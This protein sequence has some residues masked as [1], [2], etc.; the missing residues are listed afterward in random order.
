MRAWIDRY[1]ALP[2]QAQKLDALVEASPYMVTSVAFTLLTERAA[3]HQ[4][5]VSA[6]IEKDST[7]A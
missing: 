2:T 1:H 7:N 5:I 4:L 6:L 3:N